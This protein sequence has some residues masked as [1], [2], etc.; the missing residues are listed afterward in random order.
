PLSLTW[1]VHISPLYISSV[2]CL[3]TTKASQLRL[4]KTHTRWAS[5]SPADLQPVAVGYGW[6]EV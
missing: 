6:A 2:F 5:R 3:D 4:T 1:S